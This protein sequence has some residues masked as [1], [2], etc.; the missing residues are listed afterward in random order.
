MEP[1]HGKDC[2]LSIKIDGEYY[3]A[4]CAISM[5]LS[6][7]RDVV[8]STSATTGNWRQ[9]RLRRL[10]SWTVSL[11]GLTKVDNTDGQVSWFYLLQAGDGAFDIQL[12]FEDSSGNTQVMEGSAI[13][14]SQT[15]EANVSGFS[16]AT[17]DFQGTGTP[18]FA[19]IITGPS[20]PI[21]DVQ[22]TIPSLLN[23]GAVYATAPE[24]ML[25]GSNVLWVTREGTGYTETTGTPG[26]LQFRV[27]YAAGRIYFSPSNPGSIEAGESVLI[28]WQRTF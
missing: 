12:I 20:D 27:D 2:L 16:T 3:P 11:S 24:L 17:V 1:I 22:E 10:N 26:N 8:E 13:I 28:G 19:N 15:I 14:P 18:T 25:S 7:S 6:V 9:Y 23:E 21:C 4:L 5:S